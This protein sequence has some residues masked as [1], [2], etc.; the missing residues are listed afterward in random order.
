MFA[1]SYDEQSIVEKVIEGEEYSVLNHVHYML[2]GSPAS[3]HASSF[4]LDEGR[5]CITMDQH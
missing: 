5:N 3:C 4:H 1:T 2:P